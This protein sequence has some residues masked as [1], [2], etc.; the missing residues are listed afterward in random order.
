MSA[1][2]WINQRCPHVARHE[3]YRFLEKGDNTRQGTRDSTAPVIYLKYLRQPS[4]V[5]VTLP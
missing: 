4:S 2:V 1:V 5:H 3:L